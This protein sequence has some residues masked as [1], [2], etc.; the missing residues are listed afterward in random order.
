M[1]AGAKIEAVGVDR[2]AIFVQISP[3]RPDDADRF[4][5]GLWLLEVGTSGPLVWERLPKG[6]ISNEEQARH[7]AAGPDGR[8]YLMVPTEEGERIYSR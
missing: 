1:V 3:A 2:V 4:G 6:E 8:V 7:L 5:G